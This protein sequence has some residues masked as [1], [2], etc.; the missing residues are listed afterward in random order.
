MSTF[1]MVTT[2]QP[3]AAQASL[4]PLRTEFTFS[5]LEVVRA[6]KK[7]KENIAPGPDNT[8]GCVLQCRVEQLGVCFIYRQW[9]YGSTL[10]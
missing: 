8:S 6:F 3:E 1:E 7:T 4:R 2:T 9:H 10:Q 5:K